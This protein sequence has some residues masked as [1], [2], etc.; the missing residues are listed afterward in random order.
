[1]SYDQIAHLYDEYL[2]LDFDFDFFTDAAR[3]AEG[4]VLELMCG[5][6]RLS[7]PL[8]K[9]GIHLTC[10][11]ASAGML[12]KLKDKAKP[13]GAQCRIV[14]E[15]VCDM[16]LGMRF[17][18]II[19]PFHSFTEILEPERR[20]QA[21]RNFRNHLLP[22][23]R[24]I[25][26]LHNPEIRLKHVTG[27]KYLVLMKKTD[28]NHVIKL[29][30]E[31]TRLTGRQIVEATEYFEE[32][33]INGKLTKTTKWIIRYAVVDY[34]EFNQMAETCGFRQKALYGDYSRGAFQEDSSPVII[35]VLTI[36][37]KK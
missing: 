11:D 18:L 8:L 22:D 13:F 35:S 28:S 14:H 10:V 36:N 26:T 1:M 12:E 32:Y 33:D 15:N 17:P 20:I 34:A 16:D 3:S 25:I 30:L 37:A 29:W 31:E 19:L 23:G 9:S 21:L 24:L 4:P 2:Q 7:L 5:T 27:E 6:G